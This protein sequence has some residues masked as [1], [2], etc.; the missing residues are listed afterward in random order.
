MLDNRS[1]RFIKEVQSVPF[2]LKKL[3]NIPSM[4]G[5]VVKEKDTLW[6]IAKRYCTTIQSIMKINEMKS[7]NINKGDMLVIIKETP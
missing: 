3:Q 2:D 1:S 7:E 6:E 5:Y 4:A